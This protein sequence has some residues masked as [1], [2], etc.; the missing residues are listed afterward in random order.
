MN[1]LDILAGA[2]GQGTRQ[3]ARAIPSVLGQAKQTYQNFQTDIPTNVETAQRY[4]RQ[5]VAPKQY[6]PSFNQARGEERYGEEVYNQKS[7]M[8]RINYDFANQDIYM[9]QGAIKSGSAKLQPMAAYPNDPNLSALKKA[10]LNAMNL[11]P[12][13]QRYLETVPVQRG[14]LKDFVVNDDGTISSAGGIASG[15]GSS[16]YQLSNPNGSWETNTN[17]TEDPN[18]VLEQAAGTDPNGWGSSVLQHEYLHTAPRVAQVRAGME[19]LLQNLPEKSPIRDAALQYYGNGELPP[20][21]EELF[22]TLGEQYGQYALMI[23]E[24]QAYYKNIFTQPTEKENP[25]QYTRE[26]W[27]LPNGGYTKMDGQNNR[28]LRIPIKVMKKKGK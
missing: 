2:I 26:P 15:G 5:A 27:N 21:P 11:R 7:P 3:I 17:I 8:E 18:I 9:N 23:P 16:G 1:I 14:N 13:M 20:N 19:K 25:I 6:V 28:P 4:I 12:A 24:I 10:S 22:A